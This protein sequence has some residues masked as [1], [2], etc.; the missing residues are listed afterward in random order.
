MSFLF[1]FGNAQEL[2]QT[3]TDEQVNKKRP[4][5]LVVFNENQN[6]SPANTPQLLQELFSP[7]PQSSF[8]PSQTFQDQIGYQHQK[9]QTTPHFPR[10]GVEILF[11]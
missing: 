3:S 5:S 11:R 7:S 9:L 1:A 2:D 4:P 6:H 10:I 8:I